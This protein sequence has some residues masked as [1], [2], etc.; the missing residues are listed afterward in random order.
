M[1]DLGKQFIVEFITLWEILLDA[2]FL[3][4]LFSLVIIWLQF[5]YLYQHRSN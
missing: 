3:T 4:N 1:V 5:I 2:L